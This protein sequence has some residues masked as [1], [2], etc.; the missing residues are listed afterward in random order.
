ME[1]LVA[2]G[3]KEIVMDSF[4]SIEYVCTLSHSLAPSS[5]KLMEHSRLR[6]SNRSIFFAS[7]ERMAKN[8]G[9]TIKLLVCRNIDK[10]KSISERS[11][12]DGAL[13]RA[14]DMYSTNFCRVLYLNP[15]LRTKEPESV[16]GANSHDEPP[17]SHTMS[18]REYLNAR[19]NTYRTSTESE[20]S[21][22][23]LPKSITESDKDLQELEASQEQ[24]KEIEK[25][26]L[27]RLKLFKNLV[28]SM[29]E[30]DPE[31]ELATEGRLSGPLSLFVP[32]RTQ[33]RCPHCHES[34]GT[35]SL[36]I[37]VNRCRSLLENNSEESNSKTDIKMHHKKPRKVRSLIDLCLQVIMNNFHVTCMDKIYTQPEHQAALIASLPM[38]LVH[39]IVMTLVL[40]GKQTRAILDQE[41]MK[42]HQIEHDVDRLKQ[43]NFQL[44]DVLRQSLVL[45][46]RLQEQ[47]EL[48]DRTYGS[49]R[50]TKQQ[51][52]AFEGEI[53][54]LKAK[55]SQLEKEKL[56]SDAK[57]DR[58]HVKNEKLKGIVRL[59]KQH[60][61]E[62]FKKPMRSATR[63]SIHYPKHESQNPATRSNQEHDLPIKE[64]HPFLSKPKVH[65]RPGSE[66]SRIPHPSG[67]DSFLSQQIES[68]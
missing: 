54:Q 7:K 30:H 46:K 49:L 60:E 23:D 50:S 57:L 19:R 52:H 56:R 17:E 41:R 9:W 55:C 31:I 66:M 67:L 39:R 33:N 32:S 64:Y 8:D 11:V 43:S 58:L 5:D 28:T 27:G 14:I 3:Q 53:K 45:R 34:F 25:K 29:R 26:E 65:R 47:E 68:K 2:V 12:S 62:A 63:P 48:F 15:P 6:T 16:L 59:A 21:D 13:L 4:R 44:R 22:D 1:A 24:V 36:P 18:T 51:C 10:F 38:S 61:A 35:A 42:R 20:V 40:D 37:H